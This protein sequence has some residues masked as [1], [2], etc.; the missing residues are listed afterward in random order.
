MF[1]FVLFRKTEKMYY[2]S[3]C[4]KQH[5]EAEPHHGALGRVHLGRFPHRCDF[6]SAFSKGRGIKLKAYLS[7]SVVPGYRNM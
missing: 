5:R 1:C 2:L 7:V 6:A 3:L 4:K